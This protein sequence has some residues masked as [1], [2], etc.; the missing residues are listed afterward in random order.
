MNVAARWGRWGLFAVF[1]VAL[2]GCCVLPFG[3]RGARGHDRYY[4]DAPP[5]QH[6]SYDRY[7]NRGDR[8]RRGP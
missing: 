8:P 4:Q 5:P 6:G 7:D 1:A 2:S 3:P